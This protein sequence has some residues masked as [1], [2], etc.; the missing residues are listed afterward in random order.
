VACR[1]E[2]SGRGD[3]G[4]R[5]HRPY[6]LRSTWSGVVPTGVVARAPPRALANPERPPIPPAEPIAG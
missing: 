1:R 2:L 6:W 4:S 5:S 3:T